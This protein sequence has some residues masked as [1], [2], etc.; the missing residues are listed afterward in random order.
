M[1][2]FSSKVHQDFYFCFQ[3]NTLWNIITDGNTWIFI[4]LISETNRYDQF[5]DDIIA[6]LKFMFNYCFNETCYGS[7]GI[8]KAAAIHKSQL[9]HQIG[10]QRVR[11]LGLES[12]HGIMKKGIIDDLSKQHNRPVERRLKLQNYYVI[13][14]DVR[15][16]YTMST[17]FNFIVSV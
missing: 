2:H 3:C 12:M 10:I 16:E 8:K 11:Y 7:L 15:T 9:K 1:G 5:D 4:L 14:L 17:Y 6:P 13:L